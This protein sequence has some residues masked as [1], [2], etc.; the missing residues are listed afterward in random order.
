MHVGK[1]YKPY[2]FL[3]WSRRRI[4]AL[5]LVSLVPVLLYCLVGFKPVALP[6]SVVLLLGTTV[7]LI[8]G[9][10]S[11]QTYNGSVDAQQTWSAISASSRLWGVLCCNFLTTD[12][13]R[14]LIYRHIAW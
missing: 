7:A 5:L 11:T 2:E 12:A 9:F 8:A 1:S 13:A 4:L 10:K 3:S 6:W 14:K